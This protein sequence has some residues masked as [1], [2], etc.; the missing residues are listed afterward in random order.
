MK[1]ALGFVAVLLFAAVLAIALPKAETVRADGTHSHCICGLTAPN[2]TAG[3]GNK[4]IA[5]EANHVCSALTW[6]EWTLTN[7][8]PNYSDCTVDGYNCFYLAN[9]VSVSQWNPMS[10][11]HGS[12]GTDLTNRVADMGEKK[13]VICFNGHT[14]QMSSTSRFIT[15]LAEYKNSK[16]THA[17]NMDITLTDCQTGGGVKAKKDSNAGNNQGNLIW[18]AGTAGKLTIYNGTL[19][20]NGSYATT[21]K[22][23]ALIDLNSSTDF[24][25]YGGTIT[26]G[27]LKTLSGTTSG[28]ACGNLY[29]R[30]TAN[31]YGG[32][33]TAG[34][35]VATDN[36]GRGANV[37][38]SSGTF[39]MYGGTISNG[40][41]EATCKDTG[42][43][44]ANLYGTSMRISG[45]ATVSGGTLTQKTTETNN[46][47]SGG[48]IRLT[49][50]LTMTGGTISGGT[51]IRTASTGWICGGNV[52][53]PH[54]E[55]TG[56]TISGGTA[57]FGGNIY[58]SGTSNFENA[59]ITGGESTGGYGGNIAYDG[60]ATSAVTIKNCTISNGKAAGSGGNIRIGNGTL[61][62]VGT[63]DQSSQDLLV[64]SGGKALNGGNLYFEARS[65]G[66]SAFNMTGGKLSG[67]TADNWGGSVC[68]DGASCTIA[69][70]NATIENGVATAKSGGNLIIN[71]PSKTTTIK[72]TTI[73][74]GQCL[75]G[76]GGNFGMVSGTATLEN[77]TF[78]GGIANFG[79]NVSISD[80][81][82][83]TLKSGTISGGK[84]VN[85]GNGGN[86]RCDGAFTM[87]GGTIEKPVNMQNVFVNIGTGSFGSR[88]FTMNGGLIRDT[89]GGIE[90]VCINGYADGSGNSSY[91]GVFL[92]KG[93]EICQ[94]DGYV[95]RALYVSGYARLEA[96]TISG[97]NTEARSGGNI[98]VTTGTSRVNAPSGAAEEKEYKP[99][100]EITGTVVIKDGKVSNANG[101]NIDILAGGTLLMSGGTVTGGKHLT[102]DHSVAGIAV[103]DQA[104][105]T[106]TGGVITSDESVENAIWISGTGNITISGGY[107]TK[108]WARNLRNFITGGFFGTTPSSGYLAAGRLVFDANESKTIGT[109]TYA[110]TKKV[111]EGY[112]I[113]ATS[114]VKTGD[115]PVAAL[116]GAGKVEKGAA[117]TLTAPDLS[118]YTF[119]G[120]YAA[121]DLTAALTSG[122]TYQFTPAGSADF[123]ALYQYGIDTFAVKVLS[124]AAYRYRVGSGAETDGTAAGFTAPIGTEV[125]VIYAG[126]A[127]TFIG[128]FNASGKSVAFTEEYTFA[129][130]ADTTLSAKSGTASDPIVLFYTANHQLIQSAKKSELAAL[131]AVPET[132]GKT[133]ATW[134]SGGVEVTSVSDLN[135]NGAASV[136][137]IASY[138]DDTSASSLYTIQV[139]G[140]LKGTG[141][142]AT[143]T[144]L[145]GADS[146]YEN[147]NIAAAAAVSSPATA[148]DGGTDYVFSFY[149]DATGSPISYARTTTMRM[150]AGTHTVYAVYEAT[151]GSSALPVLTVITNE[152]TGNSVYFEVL[153]NVPEG[154]EIL[155]QGILFSVSSDIVYGKTGVYKYISSGKALNDVTGLTI[156]NAPATLYGR[157]FLIYKI[158]EDEG[159]L[160]TDEVQAP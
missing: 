8:L 158:G 110:Y 90:N 115:M 68:V 28:L 62:L 104:N 2:D 15:S 22:G 128:W 35:I 108:L 136:T 117:V 18:F 38:I 121:S 118:G 100:L 19:D 37:Y 6:T 154:I 58:I 87:D 5:P 64:I 60:A 53:A 130:S 10:N 137:V 86:V 146:A 98:L 88:I 46:V 74:G 93:G 69:I 61:N 48:S 72:N 113:G 71:A 95:G 78:T 66:S 21:S 150:A 81:A 129:V 20:A 30:K 133:G 135:A 63:K 151:A 82:S 109:K 4:D 47:D 97:G 55:M 139:K 23:A 41:I 75:L 50:T 145:T 70:E 31:M 11:V 125:A 45:N 132:A 84:V 96:G 152:R 111:A 99:T 156:K 105:L 85:D 140:V 33:I 144:A 91:N 101:G 92:M 1:K 42:S 119:L 56:G 54:Y 127:G 83:V 13:I 155:E 12:N 141:D 159:I 94:E 160:Y 147:L 112:Q 153:R 148:S 103:E 149:A 57:P 73:T 9:D 59:V 44:G 3:T 27:T 26:G 79:G 143:W 134:K 52:A 34:K 120:W 24:T 123:V 106:V 126:D 36:C 77:I 51:I 49:G 17:A 114:A 131:P 107:V 76:R 142:P 67:G 29:V 122:K 14:V 39:N 157:G 40:T 89:V 32:T 43:G 7:A 25:M 16:A 65:G 116:T 124:D 138:T 80:S 102:G